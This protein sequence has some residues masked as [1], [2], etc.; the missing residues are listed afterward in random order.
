MV[1]ETPQAAR[2]MPLALSEQPDQSSRSGATKRESQ[3]LWI[4]T[5]F[6]VA[7]V[8]AAAVLVLRGITTKSLGLALQ[9]TA[10][11]AFLLFWPAY[12]GG[13]MAELC[14]PIFEP[15][16]RRG[17]AFGLAFAAALTVH[18]GVVGGLFLF[19]MRPPLTG[20]LLAFFLTGA[21]W[22]YLLTVFSFGGLARMIGAKA[23]RVLRVIGLNYILCAFAFD[24]LRVAIHR[25]ADYE[26]WRLVQ[27]GPFAAM[28]IAAP[29]LVLAAAAHRQFIARRTAEGY[30]RAS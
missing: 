24:F 19:T 21:F 7:L 9:L 2:E 22:A 17:R 12:A 6:T 30:A 16:A 25:P 8:L 23:W 14:G 15:L 20:W 3:W 18:L 10:R 26:L 4:G 11:W 1:P 28:C 5:A 29:L 27:Y 13:A